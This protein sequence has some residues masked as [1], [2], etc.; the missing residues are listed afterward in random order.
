M[1][2]ITLTIS[3]YCFIASIVDIFKFLNWKKGERKT[4]TPVSVYG[5]ESVRSYFVDQEQYT[6]TVKFIEGYFV[7]QYQYLE[8]LGKKEEHKIQ[9]D[10]PTEFVVRSEENSIITV[11]DY[12]QMKKNLYKNPIL[13]FVCIVIAV[14]LLMITSAL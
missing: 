10:V 1:A 6:Y 3:V 14:V 5:P 4:G 13:C 12:E 9:L 7:H 8:R 2:A 11:K